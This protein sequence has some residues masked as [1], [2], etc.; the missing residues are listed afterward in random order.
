[1]ALKCKHHKVCKYIN[2]VPC[3]CYYRPGFKCNTQFYICSSPLD[4]SGLITCTL[5]FY[6]MILK[7]NIA[8]IEKCLTL[9]N[10]WHFWLF[11]TETADIS[12]QQW[13]SI[14]KHKLIRKTYCWFRQPTHTGFW[15]NNHEKLKLQNPA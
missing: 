1:M 7:Q 2:M 13:I 14:I 11:L 5:R 4:V 6:I 3:T 10:V 15:K 12:E 9:K 8:D